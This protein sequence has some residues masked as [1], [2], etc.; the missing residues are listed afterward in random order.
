MAAALPRALQGTLY[1]V[2]PGRF[3]RGGVKYASVLDGDGRVDRIRFEQGRMHVLSRFV[4][5]PAYLEEERADAIMHRR[6]FGTGSHLSLRTLKNEANTALVH[7]GGELLACWEGGHASALDPD[8]LA[9]LGPHA[10]GGAARVAPAFSMHPSVDGVLGI[11]GDAVCAH[12][13]VDPVTGRLVMLL[14]RF[15]VGR[16]TL[17]F[18]EFDPSGFRVHSER[19][20]SMPHFSHV[21]DFVVTPTH[22]VFFQP[23]LSF[24]ALRFRRGGS[25]IDCTG[26][27]PGPTRLV[28]LPRTGAGP[29][30][31]YDVPRCFAT[32]FVNA[33]EPEPGRL[34]VDCFGFPA[35]DGASVRV[36]AT[37]VK[38]YIIDTAS[39]TCT[40]CAP[41]DDSPAE[42]PALPAAS[43]GL[44]YRDAYWAGTL[45]APM[46]SLVHYDADTG[47]TTRATLDDAFH[48][49]PV[50]AGDFV[51]VFVLRR[52]AQ[53]LRVLEA[54]TLR[55]VCLLPMEGTNVLGLH[56]LWKG[57]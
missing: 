31:A 27:P 9:Y 2:G 33:H 6:A 39:G 30:R 53:A 57:G 16:T 28:Q 22:Y 29:A 24:D 26:Q 52:R 38:R 20:H 36:D 44:P 11:G 3:E 7:H 40:S 41:L 4:E 43:H 46:D 21:H 19:S 51:L 32:H 1:R 17:R 13:H 8:T 35:M 47:K 23:Q 37:G 55:E 14:T 15:A 45:R 12:S 5:T 54:R 50:L 49:E 10:L 34:V 48:L 56:G 25:A 18:V 42:F